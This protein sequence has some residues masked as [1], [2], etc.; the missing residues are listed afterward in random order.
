MGYL[1]AGAVYLAS[2]VGARC[3]SE[4]TENG[5]WVDEMQNKGKAQPAWL[6]LAAG[7]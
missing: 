7:A 3:S 2:C 4:S 6:Q 1:L 5:G